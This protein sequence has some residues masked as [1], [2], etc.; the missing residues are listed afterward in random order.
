MASNNAYGPQIVTDGLICCLDAHSAKSFPGA[1]TLWYNLAPNG[2]PSY[3]M[4]GWT[5]STGPQ[6]LYGINGIRALTHSES[7]TTDSAYIR[8][9]IVNDYSAKTG[10]Q[11]YQANGPI[12]VCFWTM[13]TAYATDGAQ[14]CGSTFSTASDGS[15]GGTQM[16]L[17]HGYNHPST[18]GYSF[19]LMDGTTVLGNPEPLHAWTN[20]VVTVS[21]DTTS[22]VARYYRNG[23]LH[24]QDDAIGTWSKGTTDAYHYFMRDLDDVNNF[25]GYLAHAMIYKRVLSAL[26]V[27]QNYNVLRSR[28]GK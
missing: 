26:E 7:V 19:R 5:L 1:G 17:N 10:V 22:D 21:G 4:S 24:D 13:Q 2:I 9:T 23:S 12:T 25:A 8:S 15:S 27:R 6:G 16:Q 3:T 18:N 14:T 20:H 28:F 11:W